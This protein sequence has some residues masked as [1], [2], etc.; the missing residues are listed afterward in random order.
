MRKKR[1]KMSYNKNKRPDKLPK[2]L[3][4]VKVKKMVAHSDKKKKRDKLILN[5]LYQTGLRVSELIELKKK[6]IKENRLLVRSGKGGKD[7]YIPLKPIL[8]RS[9][10][11]FVDELLGKD[12]I[13]N[14]TR[15]NV[16]RIVKKHGAVI[17]ENVYPHKL[18]H[19]FAIMCLKGGMHIRELQILLGHSDVST[20]MIYLDVLDRDIEKSFEKVKL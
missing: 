14:M 10:S 17:E 3:E 6:D 1:D 13:F 20:T 11:W 7:R 18:R 16:Y 15:Q 4:K 5:M 9:L 8:K 19:T 2:Y 12:L